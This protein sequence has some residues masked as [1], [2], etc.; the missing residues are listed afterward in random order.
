M[1]EHETFRRT[2]MPFRRG[3]ACAFALLVLLAVPAGTGA[4]PQARQATIMHW[5]IDGVQRDAIVVAPAPTTVAVKHPLVLAFHG[6]GGRMQSTALQF[7]VQTLWPQAVV[8]YPQGL[9]STTPNDP[10][11]TKPGWQ[12]KVGDSG[13]RDLKLVDAIVATMDAKYKVDRR[14]IYTTGFSNGGVFSYLLWSARPKTIA[15]VGEV[16]GRLEPPQSLA[17]PRALL[18]V[19]GRIDTVDPFPLQQQ[20]IEIARQADG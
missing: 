16:A 19:A 11:G 17:V 6:H 9:P 1:S 5:T 15:A 2:M 12:F 7:H 20:S 8:V 10:S 14:R 18:A 4:A 3:L 13:D